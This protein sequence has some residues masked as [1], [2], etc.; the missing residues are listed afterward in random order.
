MV[1]VMSRNRPIIIAID[2]PAASGKSTTAREIAHRLGYTYIDSGA[3]YRAVTLKALRENIP[4]DDDKKVSKLAEAIS[5]E[6][7]KNSSKTIIYMDGEDVSDKI[8][9]PQ[10]DRNISPVAANSHIRSIMVKKQREMGRD[11][12]VV[13]DGRDIG[14]VV[15]PAAELK[16]FMEA[17]VEERAQ[18]RLKELE[19]KGIEMDFNKVAAD[20]EY[21]DQQ[22]KSRNF[23]PLKKANDAVK[24]DTTRLSVEEQIDIITELARRVIDC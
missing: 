24:I 21:R 18:R 22:D 13:M 10:I 17:S 19:Q 6:F 14:T 16:I 15:F 9:S 4:V 20:I 1:R 11:G 5:L 12:A 3:M 23:G 2:G 8:R 7:K